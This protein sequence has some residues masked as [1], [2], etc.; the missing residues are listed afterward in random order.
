[1][2]K[3]IINFLANN[4]E[5]LVYVSVLFFLI[6]GLIYS[7]YLGDKFIF[8]DEWEYYTFAKNIADGHGARRITHPVPPR[9]LRLPH[10]VHQIRSR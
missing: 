3:R 1:M 6:A 2:G 10:V 9:R 4:P 5:K 8:P 7:F